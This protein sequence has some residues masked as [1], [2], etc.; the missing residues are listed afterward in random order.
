M[1][2]WCYRIKLMSNFLLTVQSY[3]PIQS[4]QHNMYGMLWASLG[5]D[6]PGEVNTFFPYLFLRLP[7]LQWDFSH[8]GHS[9]C[10][11][12]SEETLGSPSHKQEIGSGYTTIPNFHPLLCLPAP[13]LAHI[14]YKNRSCC[15]L[16][17]C[18]PSAYKGV[19][20]TLSVW[21]GGAIAAT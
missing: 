9:F 7:G 13:G 15:I 8:L 21:K 16:G 17:Q 18:F 4:L 1:V 10:W 6:S 3:L 2:V 19:G 20:S 12:K 5:P 11:C 14:S